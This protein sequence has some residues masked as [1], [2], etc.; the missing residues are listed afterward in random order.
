[1][2]ATIPDIPYA[3]VEGLGARGRL[4]PVTTASKATRAAA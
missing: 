1:M 2:L 3:P 4:Q